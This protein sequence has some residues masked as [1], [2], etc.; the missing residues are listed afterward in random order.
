MNADQQSSE[1]V[2]TPKVNNHI[3]R[4][5]RYLPF[6]VSHEQIY[7]ENQTDEDGLS[8]ETKALTYIERALNFGARCIVL[9]GDAGHGK[10]HLCL[11]LLRSYLGYG[12]KESRSLLKNECDGK[13]AINHVTKDAGKPTLRIHKDFS[14]ID[15]EAA[16]SFIET[17]YN[18]SDE[19]LV[20]CANEGRL[21]AVIS[22][23]SAGNVCQEL[24]AIFQQS[25]VTG[26]ASS[27][28][29]MHIVNLNFQSVA[30]RSAD[31]R[32]S[33]IRKTLRDWVSNGTRWTRSCGN[34][35]LADFCPIKRNRDLLGSEGEASETRVLI[36]GLI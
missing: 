25:F 35:S 32:D 17:H 23:R 19:A 3:A 7:E 29:L 6:S 24:L 8:L 22:S 4:L 9:T 20:I 15:P 33:L 31:G 27:D 1:I 34:C 13:H 26:L 16:A 14:E 2:K 10:T 12:F 18:L 21:R 5:T 36:S 11:K 28:G 30:A